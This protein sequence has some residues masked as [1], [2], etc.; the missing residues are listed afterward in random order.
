MKRTLL[1]WTSL[2]TALC[3]CLLIQILIN[4]NRRTKIGNMFYKVGNG[5]KK[6][7]LCNIENIKATVEAIIDGLVPAGVYNISDPIAYTY[8]DLL[9]HLGASLVFRI[10]ALTLRLLHVLG[11][12]TNNIFLKENSIKLITDNI[13]PP[14]KIQKYIKLNS[15]IRKP[16]ISND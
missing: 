14:D 13:F 5:T 9:H 8:N 7:S 4:I 11:R 12:M 6:L 2:D 10:P 3:A 15:P 1:N 16:E